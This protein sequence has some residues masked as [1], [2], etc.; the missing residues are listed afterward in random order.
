[1]LVAI[2]DDNV[3]NLKVYV[4]VVSH[5][6]GVTTQTFQSSADGL[7]WARH[8]E[9]D[10]IVLDYNMPH[11]NGVEFIEEYRKIRPTAGTPIVMITAD[12]DREVR[13]KALDAGANDFLSKPADP[14][15]FLARVKNLLAAA[16]NRKL[17]EQRTSIVADAVRQALHDATN[18]EIETVNSLMHAVEYRDNASG[19]HVIRMGQYAALLGR[20]L[21]LSAEDQR[22]LMLA[23][24]MHDVGKVAIRDAV[25]LK[26]GSLTPAEFEHVRT[27]ATVGYQLLRNGKGP[28]LKMAAAIAHGHHERWD[29]EGYPG[30]L[31]GDAIPL[32]ARICA[33]ADAFDAM[34]SE[35]PYRHALSPDRAFEELHNHSG[36][37]YDPA[38]V[39][40]ALAQRADMLAIASSFADSRPAA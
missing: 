10:L 17:L 18:H 29:G 22:V 5:V 26:I 24:P 33:V 30:A 28:V 15:E 3:T 8:T 21:G 9:P 19:M 34:I 32:P 40:V 16:Q 20:G 27:H 38:I 14:V 31:H 35:R 6:P 13:H 1:M 11:P 39:S 36:I 37:F 12:Q 2:I 7:E 4:N 23:A 25:L